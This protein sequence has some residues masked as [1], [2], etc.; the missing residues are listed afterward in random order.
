[1]KTILVKPIITEK[2]MW[3]SDQ[4][5]YAFEVG[6]DANKKEIKKAVS[7]MYSVDVLKVNASSRKPKARRYGRTTGFAK[8]KKIAIVT[9]KKGQKIQL[10]EE[11]K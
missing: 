5:K 4:F 10:L 2:S 7:D 11:S 1:M 6:K 9:L 8:G 3:M